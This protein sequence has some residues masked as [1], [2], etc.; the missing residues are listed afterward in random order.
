MDQLEQYLAFSVVK[1]D[2]EFQLHFLFN[3]FLLLKTLE[4][5]SLTSSSAFALGKPELFLEDYWS[6]FV[7]LCWGGGGGGGYSMF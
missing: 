7:C 1:N 2:H 5:F 3:L 6:R 4:L